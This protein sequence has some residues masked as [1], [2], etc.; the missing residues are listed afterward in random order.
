VRTNAP[1]SPWDGRDSPAMTSKGRAQ[2]NYI[3][4]SATF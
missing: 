2:P 3:S 4:D 1:H